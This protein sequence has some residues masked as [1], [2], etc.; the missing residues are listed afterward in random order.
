MKAF[1]LVLILLIPV[2]VLA[3]DITAESYLLIE[4][5]TFS[6]IAGKDYHKPLPPA[7]TTKVLT[8]IIALEK[9]KEKEIIVPGSKVL[10][11][12]ASKLNLLPGKQYE[13][14]D[15]IKG[16]MIESANDA[17]Y[18]L[19]V[20]VAG[21][22]ERF[23]EIMN[24]KAHEIGARDS[25]FE[26]A[27]GLHMPNHVSS[28]YDLALILRY[29]LQ[30]QR[31]Q[32]VIG[33]K[34]FMF[35]RGSADF[36]YVNHNRL[37]F[38]FEPSIGGKTG[39]TRASRHC[40]VGAFEQDGKT[41]ILAMLGSRNLWSDACAILQNVFKDVP[42]EQEIILAKAHKMSLVSYHVGKMTS[43][44]KVRRSANAKVKT[45]IQIKSPSAKKV[46]KI[47]KAKN[48]QKIVKGRK[49]KIKARRV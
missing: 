33:T 25:H 21:S 28:A 42:T 49:S 10:S 8:A 19:A 48:K 2:T 29:A 34:Y 20:A 11:I 7:S 39:F 36:K 24:E 27:S 4:K 9:L 5:D 26:N 15:L 16:A 3:G 31:F 41:Y 17:A 13:A 43:S 30:N 22:E 6:I 46:P 1:I 32:E 38:C 47:E 18:S 14:I 23:A 35:K 12:P 44:K 40:Y 45:A 37:L